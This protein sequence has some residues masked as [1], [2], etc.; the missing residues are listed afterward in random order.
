M[1]PAENHTLFHSAARIVRPVV[2]VDRSW[3]SPYFRLRKAQCASGQAN[4]YLPQSGIVLHRLSTPAGTSPASLGAIAALAYWRWAPVG[5]NVPGWVT[6]PSR[7]S[8]A[9]AG[10][11]DHL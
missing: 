9:A 8:I 3:P 11:D 7:G 4:P 1:D 10:V 2:P 5:R 6:G